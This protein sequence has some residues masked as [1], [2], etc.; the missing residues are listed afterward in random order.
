MPREKPDI[1]NDLKALFASNIKD[2]SEESIEELLKEIGIKVPG[3][4]TALAIAEILITYDDNV[5]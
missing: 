1:I 4:D 5:Q 2:K 3:I